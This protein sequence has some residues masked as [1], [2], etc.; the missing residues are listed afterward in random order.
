[1]EADDELRELRAAMDVCNRR[2]AGVLHERARL[3]RTIGAWKRQRGMALADAWREAAMLVQVG[4]LASTAGF[5]MH[6][7]QRIFAQ[8]FAESRALVLRDLGR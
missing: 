7:L 3:A 5:D 1:M 6:A 2:L 4:E 8:V